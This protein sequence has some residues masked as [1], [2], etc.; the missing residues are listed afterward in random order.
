MIG[1]PN[2]ETGK[3]YHYVRVVSKDSEK[4][5]LD[6]PY[7]SFV[8]KVEGKYIEVAQASSFTG[9]I[10]EVKSGSFDYKGIPTPTITI[11]M[12]DGD[13][14]YVFDQTFSIASRSVF[15]S[16]LSL[17]SMEQITI[18]IYLTKPNEKYGNKRFRQISLRQGENGD[19]VEWKYSIEDLPKTKK[20]RINGKEMIDS[21]ELDNFLIEKINNKFGGGSSNKNK[22]NASAEHQSDDSG[23][24]ESDEDVPF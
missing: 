6:K 3:K 9:T 7:F 20:V 5:D 2:S 24:D 15:N 14:V 4:K 8:S 19:L 22:S 10:T 23:G 1:N 21:E 16:L 17:E 11:T 12:A 18:Q 13:E